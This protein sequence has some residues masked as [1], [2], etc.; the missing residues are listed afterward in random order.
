MNAAGGSSKGVF[1]RLKAFDFF[2]KAIEDVKEKETLGAI[3]RR[4]VG[5]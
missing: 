4:T 1:R 2:P 5:S 3:G